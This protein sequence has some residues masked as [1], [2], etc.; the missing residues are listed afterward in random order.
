M[1]LLLSSTFCCRATS[2]GY[3]S[4]QYNNHRILQHM[5]KPPK[6]LFWDLGEALSFFLPCAILLC[7]DAFFLGVGVGLSLCF[8][9]RWLKR[10]VGVSA[11]VHIAY[12]YMPT[13]R[14]RMRV[15]IPSY[16]REYIG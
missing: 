7:M 5:N 4:M 3:R 6:I 12:W 15:Y 9:L 1:L 14:R 11:F 2:T 10:S 8:L 13:S 16:K